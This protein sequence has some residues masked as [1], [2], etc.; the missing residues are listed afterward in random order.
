MIISGGGP[1]MRRP[2]TGQ[3]LGSRGCLAQRDAP[4]AG[5]LRPAARPNAFVHLVLLV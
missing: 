2:S 1:E 3:G 5:M 4:R